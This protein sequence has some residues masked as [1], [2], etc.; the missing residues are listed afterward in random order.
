MTKRIDQLDRDFAAQPTR[1]EEGLRW[2]SGRD[3]R[4]TVNGLPWFEENGRAFLRFPKR[5]K[6]IVRD[7]VWELSTMPSGGR[8]RFKTD[9]TALRVRVRH[10]RP[11]LAMPHMCAVGNSG[12]DL[13]VGPPARMV[14][15]GSNRPTTPTDP[16]VHEFFTKLPRRWREVTLYLPAYNDL[17]LLEIGLDPRAGLRP[18]PRFR[19]PRPVV[20]YG[21][22]ITQGGC[23]SRSGNGWVPLLGRLLGVDVVNLGFSGNGQ[24]DLEVADL[25]AEIDA[26][27]YVNDAI[28]NMSAERMRTNYAAFNAILRRKRADTPLV[29]MTR[30]GYAREHVM[31]GAAARAQD[32]LVRRVH[33]Q[34]RRAGDRGVHLIESYSIIGRESDHPSVDG[35]HLTDLGFHRLA[36]GVAPVLKRVLGL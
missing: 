25:M 15:W 17:V 10:S 5:A 34:Y 1:R 27:C 9:S 23:A 33:R 29:L 7:P 28:A 2:Y 21:T 11:D 6:G 12:V 4:F 22:S 36:H 30:I 24:C 3:P 13:Y 32:A 16:Y 26:A 31:P 8:V 35:A 14:Y 19:L 18:P 20:V